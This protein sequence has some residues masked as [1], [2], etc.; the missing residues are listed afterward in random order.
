MGVLINFSYRIIITCYGHAGCLELTLTNGSISYSTND[1]IVLGSIATHV[2]DD[3]IG[4]VI[5]NETN[6]N[7]TCLANGW[8]EVNITCERKLLLQYCVSTCMHVND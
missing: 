1:T 2:C 5:N 7:R 4:Y 8:S 3:T 6:S